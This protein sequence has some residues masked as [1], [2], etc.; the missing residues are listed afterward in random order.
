M[1]FAERLR[2]ARIRKNMTQE[3]LAE[4][5]GVTKMS[6]SKYERGVSVPR[7]KNLTALA[8]VLGVSQLD[9]F[10]EGDVVRF[11]SVPYCMA[12]SCDVESGR[13]ETAAIRAFV[14]MLV[15]PY[16]EI[17]KISGRFDDYK[18]NEEFKKRCF[19]KYGETLQY[20]TYINEEVYRFWGLGEMPVSNVTDLLE[21]HGFVV[22]ELENN[23]NFPVRNIDSVAFFDEGYP[24]VVVLCRKMPR[25]EKRFILMS[26]VGHYFNDLGWMF[27]EKARIFNDIAILD[28]PDSERKL[29]EITVSPD[30]SGNCGVD[31]FA[32]RALMP[33]HD[34]MRRLFGT[35]EPNL[36]AGI[37][38]LSR[39]K[40]MITYE[41]LAHFC[42]VYGL[43]VYK[44]LQT[45]YYY[46]LISEIHWECLY[47][48][49]RRVDKGLWDNRTE[50]EKRYKC[51]PLPV[52]CSSWDR[53]AE[54]P[55]K[56][57]RCVYYSY[58]ND[59]I[60][61]EDAE[62]YLGKKLNNVSFTELVDMA[63]SAFCFSIP[64]DSD[65]DENT[66]SGDET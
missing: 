16:F 31:S 40:E 11:T 32:L 47:L 6:I 49:K 53:V 14:E 58:A 33:K 10:K 46:G 36:P 52:I 12:D 26:N 4:K 17:L 15:T 43:G 3:E 29:Y 35:P 24:P 65:G 41:E 20:L 13:H 45:L 9:F 18:E 27:N 50:E 64:E 23:A 59:L 7:G 28:A 34:V 5:I 1:G 55:R 57:E 42:E 8:E 44:V 25:K 39:V 30:N 21:Q 19:E 61:R 22:L 54:V 2:Q 38:S 60:S 62:K 56:F 48:G 37:K 63:A 66:D 51:K